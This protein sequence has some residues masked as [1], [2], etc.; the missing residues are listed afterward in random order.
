VLASFTVLALGQHLPTVLLMAGLEIGSTRVRFGLSRL[1]AEHEIKADR[2]R[3]R[4]SDA[5][6][7][8]N[9]RKVA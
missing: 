6:P 7:I 4:Q 5:T 8:V 1:V 3:Y 2:D 9:T